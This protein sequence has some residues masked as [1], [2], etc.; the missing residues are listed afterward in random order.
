MEEKRFRIDEVF[1]I[2]VEM[3][4]R[5]T[6]F[7]RRSA[8]STRSKGTR[9]LLLELADME[10]E[11]RRLFSSF[12]DKVKKTA[13]K[14]ADTARDEHADPFLF[15]WISGVVLDGLSGTDDLGESESL[16]EILTFAVAMEKDS[17]VFYTGLK[18][19]VASRRDREYVDNIIHEE[20]G[21]LTLLSDQLRSVK[22]EL[23]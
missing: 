20:M 18:D 14:K 23:M 8:R 10:E 5:K 16:E 7:Y 1:E 4:R 22:G 3:E 11:H 21:H 2:A 17:V 12:R 19:A 9:E 13:E 15:G 6:S